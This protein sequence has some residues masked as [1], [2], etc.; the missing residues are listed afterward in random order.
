MSPRNKS[1][2]VTQ[3][4]FIANEIEN[5]GLAKIENELE[6]MMS[7]HDRWVSSNIGID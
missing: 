2:L 7:D 5:F 1:C 3:V 6:S 4:S